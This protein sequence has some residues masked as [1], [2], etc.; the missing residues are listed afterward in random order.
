M[1]RRNASDGGP[2]ETPRFGLGSGEAGVAAS[3]CTPRQ[4]TTGMAS[5]H[6]IM[7]LDIASRVAEKL[8]AHPRIAI[9][10]D[11]AVCI[12][13]YNDGC[14][15]TLIERLEVMRITSEIGATQAEPMQ[16]KSVGPTVAVLIA[17]KSSA[18]LYLLPDPRFYPGL[19]PW[20]HSENGEH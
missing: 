2:V 7:L 10:L 17:D 16:A 15:A 3:S 13:A 12:A 20:T 8:R 1:G 4:M 11:P 9:F 5:E 14:D 19:W 6:T 18:T